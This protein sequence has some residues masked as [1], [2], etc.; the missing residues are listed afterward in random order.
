MDG[1]T[2]RDTERRTDGEAPHERTRRDGE[3]DGQRRTGTDGG[4]PA[5]PGLFVEE[6]E[7]LLVQR[8][9]RLEPDI[10]IYIYI[11]IY[12]NIYIYIYIERER[13]RARDREKGSRG[14]K[15]RGSSGWRK[16][17]V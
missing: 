12:I 6:G 1:R 8:L 7:L 15:G 13:E 10:Y 17:Q 14:A 5:L 2:D 9:W 3:T 4:G 11:Y 16:P